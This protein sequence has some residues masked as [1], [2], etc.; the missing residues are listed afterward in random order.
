MPLKSGLLEQISNDSYTDDVLDLSYQGITD[1]EAEQLAKALE[2]NSRINTL[3]LYCNAIGDKGAAA[4]AKVP[5]LRN[6]DLSGGNPVGVEGARCLAKSKLQSLNL[7]GNNTLGDDGLVA[8]AGSDTITELDVSECGITDQGALAIFRN[9]S[10]THLSLQSNDITA[11][12]VAEI[13]GNN[14]LIELNL[15]QNQVG[16]QGAEKIAANKS[17]STVNLDSNSLGDEGATFL[18]KNGNFKHLYLGQNGIGGEGFLA[19]CQI[20]GLATLSLF[21]NHVNF[22]GIDSLPENKTI[23][24]INLAYNQICDEPSSVLNTLILSFKAL[25]ELNLVNN[26]LTNQAAKSLVNQ[27]PPSLQIELRSPRID[28][29]LITTAFDLKRTTSHPLTPPDREEKK[30]QRLSTSFTE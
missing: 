30:R 28:T 8:L 19:L 5:R 22:T 9:K 17:L 10:I 27:K 11:G 23:T 3:K 29:N 25:K 16:P 1:S 20:S 21:N 13:A 18:A 6:L 4:L 24:R 14:Q 26:N 15:S 12:G 7:A 2:N